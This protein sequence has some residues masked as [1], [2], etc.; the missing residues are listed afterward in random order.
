MALI[1]IKMPTSVI[2]GVSKIWVGSSYIF[3]SYNPII[4]GQ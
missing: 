4:V 2:Y 3:I 1:M